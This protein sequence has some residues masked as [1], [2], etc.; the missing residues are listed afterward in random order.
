V[1]TSVIPTFA[2]CVSLAACGTLAPKDSIYRGEYFYTAGYS[3][4]TPE[5]KEEDWCVD[6]Y[7]SLMLPAID[8]NAQSSTSQVVVRGK[9]G[10]EDDSGGLGPC[11]RVLVVTEILEVTNVRGGGKWAAP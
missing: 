10:P 5:G 3:L 11:Y 9:L 8:A 2:L 4:F 6:A 7:Y 1:K